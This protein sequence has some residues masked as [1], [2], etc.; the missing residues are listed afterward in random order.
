MAP[1]ADNRALNILW[2]TP[3]VPAFPSE[4]QLQQRR[5]GSIPQKCPSPLTQPYDTGTPASNGFTFSISNFPTEVHE[6]ISVEQDP[7]SAAR[8][9]PGCLTVESTQDGA[10]LAPE[11][12][13][14]IEQQYKDLTILV[15]QGLKKY[16]PEIFELQKSAIDLGL[17]SKIDIPELQAHRNSFLTFTSDRAGAYYHLNIPPTP[18]E[19]LHDQ[20]SSWIPLSLAGRGRAVRAGIFVLPISEAFQIQSY[21]EH[22]TIVGAC[23]NLFER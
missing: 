2:S 21:H 20:Y 14:F 4:D 10:L 18:R 23:K 13:D 1:I 11:E 6:S 16:A 7:F 3:S 5:T 19:T 8:Y 9:S 17:V 22:D 15:P 12:R